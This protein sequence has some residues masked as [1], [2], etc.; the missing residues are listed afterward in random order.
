MSNSGVLYKYEVESFNIFVFPESASSGDEIWT[1]RIANL[2]SR[3]LGR[4]N[5]RRT[6]NS[7]IN[8]K[9]FITIIDHGNDLVDRSRQ[10]GVSKSADRCG[11]RI[12]E[13]YWPHGRLAAQ[14]NF[15]IMHDWFPFLKLQFSLR[16]P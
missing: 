2:R 9:I 14:V 5:L 15:V 16:L 6:V 11:E 4:V 10:F 13:A 1:S 12:E 3:R 8:S 7:Q